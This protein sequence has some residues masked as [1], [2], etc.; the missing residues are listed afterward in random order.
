M[1]IIAY[2]VHFFKLITFVEHA[3]CNMTQAPVAALLFVITSLGFCAPAFLLTH[4]RTNLESNAYIDGTIPS[5]YPSKP[6]ADNKVYWN[7]VKVACHGHTNGNNCSA[8]I[9]MGTN[10]STPIDVGYVTLNLLTGD[11][12]PKIIS[13]NGFTVTVNGPGETTITQP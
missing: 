2:I 7:M 6:H 13:A 4:N 8:L 12:N 9:K 11:I 5:L 3:M 1:K 10:T